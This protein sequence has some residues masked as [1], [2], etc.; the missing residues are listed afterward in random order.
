MPMVKK[1]ITVTDVQNNWLQSQIEQGLYASDSEVLRD[2]IR[3]KQK[4]DSNNLRIQAIRAALIEGEESGFSKR[5]PEDIK[6]A[7]LARR[8]SNG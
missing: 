4:D 7:V 6:K 5:T 8:L 1:S 3:Q 2:L